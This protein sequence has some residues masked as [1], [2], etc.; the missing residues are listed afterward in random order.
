MIGYKLL[1]ELKNGEISSLF[2]NKKQRIKMGEWMMS[3]CYPTKGFAV[4]P[5]FHVL[6]RPLAPHLGMEGRAW[7]KVE[8]DDVTLMERPEA[9]G[10]IW[11]LC[12]RMKVLS[13]LTKKEL[14]IANR[15]R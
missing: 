1:R 15:Q 9:Q 11:M 8:I 13:K 2:I 12:G 10:G 3:M 7:Y 5:G 4:R 6:Q 14:T